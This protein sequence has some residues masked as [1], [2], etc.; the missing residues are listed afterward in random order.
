MEN[1]MQ[2]IESML[3]KQSKL[4][5]EDAVYKQDIDELGGTI[6]VN[7]DF[8]GSIA[9]Q[10]YTT[11][12]CEGKA[13]ECLENADLHIEFYDE[14]YSRELLINEEVTQYHL[15]P[16]T[17]K[18][19]RAFHEFGYFT[20]GKSEG[21]DGNIHREAIPL[22]KVNV[23]EGFDFSYLYVSRIPLFRPALDEIF[24][25]LKHE[26]NDYGIYIPI[27]ESLYGGKLAQ[28]IFHHF[29]D[30]TDNIFRLPFCPCRKAYG[31]KHR[32]DIGC[33][34]MGEGTLE[35]PNPETRGT[36]IEREEAKEVL[37]LAIEDG[38]IPLL[39]RASG[40]TNAFGIDDDGR[41]L[42]TC[43]C[44]GDACF[45]ATV[46]RKSSNGADFIFKRVPGLSLVVD[47]EKCIGCGKC[48]KTCPYKGMK[49]ADKKPE[50]IERCFG[51]GQCEA[52]CPVGAISF[53]LE[54]DYHTMVQKSIE[55]I[56]KVV[57]VTT[58][59]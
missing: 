40:E 9:Y 55:A 17:L 43:Y 18:L 50:I 30:R 39:G 28:E 27:N 49:W 37:A 19:K 26:P 5:S 48:M 4:C 10:V 29:I 41:F 33:I 56:E 57:D 54:Y 42:S 11:D 25:P 45:N 53:E 38:L 15:M 22:F 24:K 31:S 44:G 59:G 23:R 6:R 14:E 16:G 3:D 47:R 35:M 58:K 32:V 20:G 13:G 12:G 46:C 7:W 2:L 34:H 21:I 1:M 51:C 8:A 36:Y 52:V